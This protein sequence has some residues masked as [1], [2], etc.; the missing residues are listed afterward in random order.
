VDSLP[1]RIRHDAPLDSTGSITAV[2][3]DGRGLRQAFLHK[4]MCMDEFA[5]GTYIE[6]RIGNA[7]QVLSKML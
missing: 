4:Y 7:K 2:R 5:E 6:G 3:P 1:N